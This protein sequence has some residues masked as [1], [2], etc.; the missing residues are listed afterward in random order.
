[1][2]YALSALALIA[3]YFLGR[4]RQHR[5]SARDR[6]SL[7]LFKKTYR[8]KSGWMVGYGSYELESIDG[9]R[10]WLVVVRDDDGVAKVVG[11]AEKVFPGLV[12]KL[13][14]FVALSD[15]ARL[16][17][18][19]TLSGPRAAADERMLNAA[20]FSIVRH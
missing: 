3:T 4:W 14:A 20:G 13:D 11:D 1:M 5:L 12:A 6:E 7:A 15:H 17:G 10:Q 18:P 9:G 19:L 16:H 2:L 8:R